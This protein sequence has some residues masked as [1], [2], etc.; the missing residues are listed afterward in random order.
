MYHHFSIFQEKYKCETLS[1]KCEVDSAFRI[2]HSEFYAPSVMI[3]KASL[4]DMQFC[5]LMIYDF[6]EINDIHTTCDFIPHSTFRIPHSIPPLQKGRVGCFCAKSTK[7][8]STNQALSLVCNH[9]R[10]ECNPCK[11]HGINST[12]DNIQC[13]ALIPYTFG[14]AIPTLQKGRVGCFLCK[15][16]KKRGGD[17]V[18]CAY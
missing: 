16:H 7:Q 2:P 4:D 3:Y 18:Y 1:E 11:R 15:R 6:F 5:E 8:V 14:D 10:R 12:R 13:K 9:A 17:F